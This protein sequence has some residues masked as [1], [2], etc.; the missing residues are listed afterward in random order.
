MVQHIEDGI[1]SY[2]KLLIARNYKIDPRSNV[3]RRPD[4]VNTFDD[5]KGIL[6]NKIR[7]A[8]GCGQFPSIRYME[9]SFNNNG[10]LKRLRFKIY[11]SQFNDLDY[12]ALCEELN[13][14]GKEQDVYPYAI[15]HDI[16]NIVNSIK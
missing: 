14:Y 12:I 5:L 8:C 10:T 11:Y 6:Y 2:H 3:L 4:D 1:E 7:K 15:E 9:C 16:I 13:K